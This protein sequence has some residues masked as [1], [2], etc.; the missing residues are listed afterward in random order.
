MRT[1]ASF[2]VTSLDGFY[3]GSDGDFDWMIPDEEFNDFAVRQ[4]DE[5]DTLGF[6]RAT[7]EHMAAY[8]PSDQAQANDPAVTSRMNTKPKLVFSTTLE[9]AAWS[10]T[11]VIAGEA[12]E[13]M[14]TV[15]TAPGGELLVLGSTH[16]TAHLAG[17]GVLDE[18]RIMICPIAL[19]RGRSLFE[20]LKGRLALTLAQ[21]RPFDSGN[22]LLT[23]RV[24]PYSMG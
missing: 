3:E 14:G 20:D 13:Q 18:L 21:V 12:V 1:L 5:A 15:K 22:V 17:A 24:P 19:G 4:L 10:N 7:Y 9:Q 11:T 2:I 16:L 8:W 6:G 23:Y